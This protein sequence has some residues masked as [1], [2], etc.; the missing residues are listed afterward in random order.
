M[1]EKAIIIFS[2]KP[3]LGKVKTRIATSL[4]D[5]TALE[6]YKELLEIT[7]KILHPMNCK[8][9]LFW[10]ELPDESSSYLDQ[11]FELRIQ[12]GID[13]GERMENAFS[14]VIPFHD[15]VIIVGTDCPYINSNLLEQSFVCLEQ[16]D[17]VIGPAT[18]GGYYLLGK[19]VLNT[20]IFR[21]IKWSTDT[22]LTETIQTCKEQN[23]KFDLLMELSDI[24]TE[25]DY[26]QW[27]RK[28]S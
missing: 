11:G 2:K 8:K 1:S 21:N 28:T 16:S 23:L 7:F 6:I 10:D 24:D 22:V 20:K 13:L 17:I 26:I 9:Y 3:K 4:G 19:K 27:K 14:E 12:K 5:S 25:A 15:K 18:D